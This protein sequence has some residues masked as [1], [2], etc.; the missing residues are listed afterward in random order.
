[1]QLVGIV[2]VCVAAGV[3]IA[4]QREHPRSDLEATAETIP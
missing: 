1:V 3:S 2:A 4:T